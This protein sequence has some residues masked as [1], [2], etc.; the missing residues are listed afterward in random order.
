M[1]VCAQGQKSC[2]LLRIREAN[3]KIIYISTLEAFPLT[4]EPHGLPNTEFIVESKALEHIALIMSPIPVIHIT[5]RVPAV[6][7]KTDAFSPS[8]LINKIG[9]LYCCLQDS[10]VSMNG[11]PQKS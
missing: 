6:T 10:F 11:Y 8:Y 4:D 9:S 1:A 2:W 3:L 7:V 5:I